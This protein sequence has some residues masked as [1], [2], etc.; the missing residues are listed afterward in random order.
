MKIAKDGKPFDVD[1][2]NGSQKD[3]EVEIIQ[4]LRPDARRRR[5]VAK[6]GTEVAALAKDLVLTCEDLGTGLI[7]LTARF[8]WQPEEQ[9]CSEIAIN[10]PGAGSPAK[11][12]AVLIKQVA[13]VKKQGV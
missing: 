11:V 8:T 9:E 12:L 7:N 4:Y 10:G 5:M 3:D 13:A 6:V 2:I 1:N